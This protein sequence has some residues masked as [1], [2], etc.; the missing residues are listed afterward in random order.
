MQR[1]R[2]IAAS[3]GGREVQ[4]PAMGLLYADA[5]CWQSEILIGMQ[6]DAE[7]RTI[8]LESDGILRKVLETRPYYRRAIH[9]GQIVELDLATLSAKHLDPAAALT[10]A[11][12]AWQ[13]A[14]VELSLDA[15]SSS[16]INNAISN[17][18][19][20]GD[21][22]FA[23]GRVAESIDDYH[24]TDELS[25]RVRQSGTWFKLNLLTPYVTL[26]MRLADSGADEAARLLAADSQKQVGDIEKSASAG[27]HAPLFADCLELVI[28]GQVAMGRGDFKR[29]AGQSAAAAKLVENIEPATSL[30]DNLKYNCIVYGAVTRGEAELWI[31]DNA[32]AD[33]TLA[34]ANAGRNKYESGDVN[35]LR[36]ASLGRTLRALAMLRLGKQTEARA[37]IEPE[38]KFERDL[39]MENRG[40]VTQHFELAQ[41]LYVESLTD[42][43]RQASLQHEALA[44]VDALPLEFAR[45]RST[46]RWRN[47][48]RHR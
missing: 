26:G 17:L 7:A 37:L 5:G 30:E 33:R 43:K 31:D 10:E 1:A 45:L 15:T 48:M 47:L 12:R 8:D 35:E 11:Q 41:T 22:A 38:V 20:Q 39:A 3:L 29:A 4:T 16:A 23:L 19:I 9:L 32:A 18:L 6:H 2:E 46:E 25:E 42:Q 40:D 36:R 44:L 13:L 14:Q 28:E 34:A 21:L 24:R 27:S